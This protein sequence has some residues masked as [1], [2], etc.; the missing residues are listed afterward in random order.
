M[1][2]APQTAFEF[3][4]VPANQADFSAIANVTGLPATAFPVGMTTSGLP[5]SCQV[6]TREDATTLALAERLAMTVQTPQGFRG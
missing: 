1:P 6:V 5:L 4:T 3:G 2:T